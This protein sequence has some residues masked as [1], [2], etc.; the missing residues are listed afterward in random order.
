MKDQF[1]QLVRSDN[2]SHLVLLSLSLAEFVAARGLAKEK[3]KATAMSLYSFAYFK[4][5][6]F[7]DTIRLCVKQS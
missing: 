2:S 5:H 1:A 7:P 6:C 4:R 3:A